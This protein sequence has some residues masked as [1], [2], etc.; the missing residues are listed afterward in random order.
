MPAKYID[1]APL[2]AQ[3]QLERRDPLDHD[4][5]DGAR[6][7]DP[8]DPAQAALGRDPLEHDA[9]KPLEL[10]R[11]QLRREA[12]RRDSLGSEIG[13]EGLVDVVAG[14]VKFGPDAVDKNG[15]LPNPEDDL[16]LRLQAARSRP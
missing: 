9:D 7:P 15:I 4:V 3:T 13:S 12:N 14:I 16:S 10:V 6:R 2:R 1:G 5:H 11:G 8:E